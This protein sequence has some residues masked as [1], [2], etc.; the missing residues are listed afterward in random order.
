[1]GP[2]EALSKSPII[3]WKNDYKA[4][5]VDG[6]LTWLH[7]NC[8]VFFKKAYDSEWE[9][10]IDKCPACIEA[11]IV[12]ENSSDKTFVGL[13]KPYTAHLKK[14]HCTCSKEDV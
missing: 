14:Y 1:M 4:K 9:P 3:I 8:D 10:V 2:F 7:S 13:A 12:F 5:L 6:R 11:E